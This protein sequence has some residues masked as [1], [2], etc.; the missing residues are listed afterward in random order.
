MQKLRKFARVLL[1]ACLLAAA[2]TVFAHADMGPKNSVTVEFRGFEGRQYYATLLS[3]ERS[4]GPE[5]VYD[6]EE[7][8]VISM[9]NAETP[10]TQ[11]FW[12]FVN[13]QDPDGFYFVQNMGDCSQSHIFGW[14][15]YPPVEFKI[16]LYF[17][18]TDEFLGSEGSCGQYAFHSRYV[19][20]PDGRTERAYDYGHEVLAFAVRAL[21]TI[22]V[23]L[24]VALCFRLRGGKLWR[25]IILVNLGTQVLLNAALQFTIYLHGAWL[26]A[27]GVYLLLELGVTAAEAVVYTRYFPRLGT[28]P[29]PK[30]VGWVYALAANAVSFLVGLAMAQMLTRMF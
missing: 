7:D 17:P 23:E 14:G 1:C 19:F 20:T 16:L 22:A 26:E 30:W 27:A 10:Y 21:L 4:T 29:R 12:K 28:R 24:A 18:D 11:A 13:Y 3:R 25:L 8:P 9:E 15:Y 6:G 5:S 2:M